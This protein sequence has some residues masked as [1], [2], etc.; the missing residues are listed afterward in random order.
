MGGKERYGCTYASRNRRRVVGCTFLE[1]KWGQSLIEIGNRSG[2]KFPRLLLRRTQICSLRSPP[3]YSCRLVALFRAPTAGCAK[4]KGLKS[5]RSSLP[6]SFFLSSSRYRPLRLPT[7]PTIFSR[8]KT[9]FGTDV[10]V[11]GLSAGCNKYQV[12]IAVMP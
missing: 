12:A 9:E 11:P 6:L 8:S 2:N 4:A 5:L 7:I 10:T 3:R 1:I